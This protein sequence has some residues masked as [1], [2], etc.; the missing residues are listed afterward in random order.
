MSSNLDKNFHIHLIGD[1]LWFKIE[2][3]LLHYVAHK[4][5]VNLQLNN[6]C[7]IGTHMDSLVGCSSICSYEKYF[8]SFFICYSVHT[9]TSTRSFKFQ[10]C[11]RYLT[12][13]PSLPIS[14]LLLLL[15]DNGEK[16]LLSYT[17]KGVVRF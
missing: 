1:G 2:R 14:S 5:Q 13:N 9:I 4:C 8:S 10:D 12:N 6:M 17:A 16:R 11:S 7:G 3:G 15:L